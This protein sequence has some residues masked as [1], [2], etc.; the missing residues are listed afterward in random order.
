MTE[1]ELIW[2]TKTFIRWSWRW[3]CIETVWAANGGETNTCDALETCHRINNR[4]MNPWENER[5]FGEF[6]E[7]MCHLVLHRSHSM[8]IFLCVFSID[9]ELKFVF[10][11]GSLWWNPWTVRTFEARSNTPLFGLLFSI[12]I[13]RRTHSLGMPYAFLYRWPS[14]RFVPGWRWNEKWMKRTILD[15]SEIAL[16]VLQLDTHIAGFNIDLRASRSHRAGEVI[17]SINVP[18]ARAGD[19]VYMSHTIRCHSIRIHTC[20]FFENCDRQNETET[21]KIA[22]IVSHCNAQLLPS[23]TRFFQCCFVLSSII[24]RVLFLILSPFGLFMVVCRWYLVKT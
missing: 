14:N 23:N 5:R 21:Q 11:W 4:Y 24:V 3:N 6:V 8:H 9:G 13:M 22:Y 19:S 1:N 2:E 18:T 12:V 17:R 20:F 16:G 15:S 10:D 7:R